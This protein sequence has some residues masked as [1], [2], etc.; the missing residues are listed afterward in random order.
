MTTTI[1]EQTMLEQLLR[2]PRLPRYAQKI[3]TKLADES[4]QRQEFY[5]QITDGDKAEFINGEIIF[6]SPVKL[7]H[8]AS[9]GN[10]YR[11]L[12]TFVMTHDLG[13]VGYEKILIALSRNDYEPDICYFNPDKAASFTPDQMRFP[14]PD[15]VV[16]VLS[17]STEQN[18]RGVK[19]EDYADH[20]VAEYWIVDPDGE[21]VE[22]YRLASDEERAHYEL[23]IK[24]QTGVIRSFV[25]PAFEIPVR[26][27]FDEQVSREALRE[28]VG[29]DK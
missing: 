14:A 20:G 10:L 21:S 19:F 6:H 25:L 9:S 2:S 16:E 26:A 12:S 7:R 17:D 11:L 4:E 3:Q 23:H 5:R 22:Q 15:L 8:N 29:K 24:A 13:F 18:D 1:N 28:M 27:I